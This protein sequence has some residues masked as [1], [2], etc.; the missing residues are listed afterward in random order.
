[1]TLDALNLT[2]ASAAGQLIGFGLT[3]GARPVEGSEYRALLDRY[4]TDLRFKDTVD[5]FAEGLGLEVLGT[6]RSG[7]VLAPE[8]N[9]PF[10]NRL[11]DLKTTMDAE[12]KLV[13]GLILVALAAYAYPNEV[14]LD[15]PDTKLV[16]V[17]KLDDFIRAGIAGLQEL[18]GADGSTSERARAA[19]DAYADMPSLIPTP[20][21][22]RKQGCTLRAIEIV[23]GWMVEQGAAR[24]QKSLGPDTYQ[25]TDRFRL[26]VADS[27]GSEA[28]K[29]LRAARRNE[30]TA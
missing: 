9:G 1:M 25:L 12:E 29:V 7:L 18:A 17:V 2:D 5:T 22:R 10:A 15:E 19:A 16:D 14:D 27:A 3:R 11:A 8:P 13:F 6:P 23:C 20:Q 28:L 30:V 21:G 26:L 4:R 24:E